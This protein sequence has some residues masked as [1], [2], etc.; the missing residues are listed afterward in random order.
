MPNH[1]IITLLLLFAS[2]FTLVACDEEKK[3][4]KASATADSTNQGP[5]LNLKDLES[6]GVKFQPLKKETLQPELFVPGKVTLPPNNQ[7]RVTANIGGLIEK[8]MVY[9]GQFVNKGQ[10]IAILS[11]LELIELQQAFLNAKNEIAFLEKEFDRQRILKEKNYGALAEYQQVESRYRNAVLTSHSLSEKLKVL[12]LNSAELN[13]DGTDILPRIAVRSPIAG[14]VFKLPPILGLKVT[15][16]QIL[17]DIISLDPLYAELNV[18]EK[19]LELVRE[20]QEV[21][22]NFLN[23]S[24][25]PVRGKISHISKGIDPTT[26]AVKVYVTFSPPKGISVLPEMALKVEIE[27]K[28]DKSFTFTAPED[29]IIEEG[30]LKYVLVSED[31][32]KHWKKV[33]ILIGESDGER[34]QIFPAKA[35][36]EGDLIAIANTHILSAAIR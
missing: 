36:K 9:E 1:K 18:F 31:Q 10:P 30:E 7:A 20:N 12:G 29:A 3:D 22:I 16:E 28:A 17:A 26:R 2:A 15:P 5:V 14:Y 25:A 35:V 19:D 24:I 13:L 21:D 4:A 33:K 11:S 34:V 8:V 6:M 32:G 23:K 27:G